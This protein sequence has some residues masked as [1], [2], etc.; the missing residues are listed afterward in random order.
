MLIQWEVRTIVDPPILRV[1]SAPRLANWYI[2]IRPW[3]A[4][5]VGGSALAGYQHTPQRIDLH[6]LIYQRS[7]KSYWMWFLRS[8]IY[9]SYM[10]HLLW[11]SWS[12]AKI[13]EY[14]FAP[15]RDFAAL[16][17]NVAFCVWQWTP[18]TN[19]LE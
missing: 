2:L 10:R 16:C 4:C 9:L 6:L 18:Y 13:Y 1:S 3:C 14:L 17:G 19:S 7:K 12:G 15:R 8:R 5:D 11:L